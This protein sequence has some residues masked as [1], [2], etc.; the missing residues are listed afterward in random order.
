MEKDHTLT[1]FYT[2]LLEYANSLGIVRVG[3]DTD[4]RIKKNK[5]ELEPRLKS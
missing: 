1:P 5:Q 3:L 4:E 2:K